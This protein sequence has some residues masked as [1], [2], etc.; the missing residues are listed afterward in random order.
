MVY[1]EYEAGVGL[2][3]GLGPGRR[4]TSFAATGNRTQI[5]RL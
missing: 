2:R 1:V 4:G 5:P 3:A